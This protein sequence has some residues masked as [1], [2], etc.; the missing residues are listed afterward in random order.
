MRRKAVGFYWTLP[1]PWAGFN[2]LPA[3]VDEAAKCS[4][5]IRYQCELVR[6]YAK[7]HD[8]ELIREEVFMEVQPDRSTPNITQELGILSGFCESHQADILYVD[9]KKELGWRRNLFMEDWMKISPVCCREIPADSIM[10]DYHHFD[11]KK[12]FREWRRQQNEWSSLKSERAKQAF[13]RAATLRAEGLS[14]PAVAKK[15][16]AGGLKSLSGKDWKGDNVR[17][18]LDGKGIARKEPQ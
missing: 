2:E 13:E 12:H 5:T 1:V 11:P 3:D 7:E 9:F 16:N 17:K 10:I 14:Y 6:R 18:L 15:M 4:R 8:F